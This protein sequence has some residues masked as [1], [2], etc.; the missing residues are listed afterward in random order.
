MMKTKLVEGLKI[1][2]EEKKSGEEQE[3]QVGEL[4]SEAEDIEER[5]ERSKKT[6]KEE[7]IPAEARVG[8]YVRCE[9]NDPKNK[10]PKLELEDMLDDVHMSFFR[11]NAEIL[12]D[13]GYEVKVQKPK[14]KLF[15]P[16]AAAALSLSVGFS[17]FAGV[18]KANITS[19]NP[20]NLFQEKKTEIVQ[21]AP[22]ID[23]YKYDYYQGA[24]RIYSR[25]PFSGIIDEKE[26]ES[27]LTTGKIPI[28]MY[29][30]IGFPEDR[31]TVSPERFKQHLKKLSEHGFQLISL[32]DYINNDFSSLLP[33]K[34]AAI[35]TFDDADQG[36]FEFAKYR[37][38]LI[39]DS[40]GNPLIEP[41]CA[42]RILT[43]FANL[44][45]GFGKNAAFFIDFAN[46]AEYSSNRDK[47]HPYQ[48]PFMQEDLIKMKLLYLL[49]EGF[50]VCH[51]T[52]S[53]PDMSMCSLRA[54]ENEVEKS[55]AAFEYYLGERASQVKKY[56]A[57]P[58]GA[59]PTDG[60][61]MAYLRSNFDATF[62]AWG[63]MAEGNYI[64]NSG[65]PVQPTRDYDGYPYPTWSGQ[66]GQSNEINAPYEEG[67]FRKSGAKKVPGVLSPPRIEISNNLDRDVLSRAGILQK[68]SKKQEI[69]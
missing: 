19:L 67:A 59:I 26:E 3:Q 35:I 2:I 40:Q 63:G 41:D 56:L 36:Q 23:Q 12:K 31:F 37:G 22:N 18:Y 17:G 42:V 68:K 13:Y 7:S 45:P 44:N 21:T 33:G 51:H 64:G 55:K 11:A 66:S 32:E 15:K 49:K 1:R 4:K 54:I 58:Y 61:V 34:K 48:A 52:Y 8:E 25:M 69:K 47:S 38:E 29:H 28:L 9:A 46:N 39:H 65:S 5:L 43:E 62:A 60:N 27:L 57:F 6:F 30:K 16:F 50:E 24:G 53:H 14:N 20:F 10:K